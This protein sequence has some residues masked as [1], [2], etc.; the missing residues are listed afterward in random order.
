VIG[1]GKVEELRVRERERERDR[2]TDR[3]T[4]R[5]TERQRRGIK[6]AVYPHAIFQPQVA[7]C[8]QG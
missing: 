5:Q 8:S 1:Q 4:E 7:M 6:M 2:E 3:E